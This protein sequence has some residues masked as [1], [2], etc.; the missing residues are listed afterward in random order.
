[1]GFFGEI[2]RKVQGKPKS[3]PQ[4]SKTT[5]LVES[6]R[7]KAAFGERLKLERQSAVAEERRRFARPTGFIETIQ[8]GFGSIPRKSAA[9]QRIRKRRN[10]VSRPARVTGRKQGRRTSDDFMGGGFL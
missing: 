2:S 6:V 3:L 5:S 4:G 8:A 10:K 1:M 7:R 9:R